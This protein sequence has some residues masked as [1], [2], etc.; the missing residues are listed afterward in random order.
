M[1]DDGDVVVLTVGPPGLRFDMYCVFHPDGVRRVLTG[2]RSGYTKNNRMYAQIADAFGWG[3]LTSEGELWQRHRRLIQ[4]LFTRK[5]IGGYIDLMAEEAGALAARWAG[6]ESVDANAESVR[7]SLRVLGRTVFGDEVEAAGEVLDR[8]FPVLNGYVF[9]RAM[10]PVNTPASWPTRANR[11]AAAARAALY[12]VVDRFIEQRERELRNGRTGD[13][14]ITRLLQARDPDTGAS[15]NVQEVRDQALIFLL[16]GHETTSTALAFTLDQLGRHDEEQA[17]VRHE[18]DQVLAGRPPGAADLPHLVR[19]TMAVK[20]AMRLYPP[21]YAVGRR[22][23]T[24]DEIGG[25][26]IPTG[27]WV[28]VSQWATHRHPEYWPEPERYLPARFDPTLEADRHPYAYFPFGGGPRACIGTQF[29]LHEAVLTVAAVVQ[30]CRLRSHPE[31]A[32]V[33]TFGITL[34]PAG[35]VRL[36]IEATLAADT[37]GGHGPT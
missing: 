18:V 28:T 31:P 10:S 6:Q 13:D 33:D 26:R 34:R 5:A 16:A 12:G 24:E 37:I 4:P 32:G 1:R 2:S 35:P 25:Y 17:A 20:E 7:L 8:A 27:A 3:L 36:A 21:A 29:A 11:E 19:T 14:L 30:R 23:E 22:L 15:M 9:R